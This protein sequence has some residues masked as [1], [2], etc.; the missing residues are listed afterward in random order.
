[1]GLAHRWVIVTTKTVGLLGGVVFGFMLAGAR[2]TDPRVI[3]DMW[4]L[5]EAEQE[6]R[7]RHPLQRYLDSKRDAP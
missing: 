2:L 1:M 5:T 4:L 6:T 3:R 7:L